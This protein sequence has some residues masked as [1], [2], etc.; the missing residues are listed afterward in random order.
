VPLRKIQKILLIDDDKIT[1]YLNEKLI[2]RLEMG[3]EIVVKANGKDALVYLQD[4]E[5]FPSLILLDINMPGMNAFDFIE[6]FK[7]QGLDKKGTVIVILTISDDLDDMIRLKYLGKYSYVNK[8]LTE[9]KMTGIYNDY[10][11]EGKEGKF[12]S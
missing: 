1:N 10:F 8:P 9:E 2:L 11:K 7:R 12:A 4:A 6:E 3:R 5:V